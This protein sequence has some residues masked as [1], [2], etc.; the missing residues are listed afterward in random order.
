MNLNVAILAIIFNIIVYVKMI[1]HY[2][3]YIN[4]INIII[5]KNVNNFKI[6]ILYIDQNVILETL[7]YLYKNVV[8][9]NYA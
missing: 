2:L 3:L 5:H 9:E 8:H 1:I 6:L 4:I 7:L